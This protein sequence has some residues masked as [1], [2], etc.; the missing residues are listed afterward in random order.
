MLFINNKYESLQ[1]IL[2][3][4]K[5]VNEVEVADE[6]LSETGLDD[7]TSFLKSPEASG[8]SDDDTGKYKAYLKSQSISKLN[9]EKYDDFFSKRK[10]DYND[11]V[12]SD[13]IG[14]FTRYDQIEALDY[15]V[16]AGANGGIINLSSLKRAHN[17]Y[18]VVI[19]K[20]PTN[21]KENARKIL[22]VMRTWKKPGQPSEGQFEV[23]L[24]FVLKGG[25]REGST[26]DVT[27][28]KTKMEVKG[29]TV[30]TGA[31]MKGEVDGNVLDQFIP[32][33]TLFNTL[34]EDKNIIYSGKGS[35]LFAKRLDNFKSDD[36]EDKYIK[37][38]RAIVEGA[39][40]QVT[41]DI[42]NECVS[43]TAKA[44]QSGFSI[45]SVLGCVHLFYYHLA[46]NFNA[47]IVIN[48]DNGDC[49]YTEKFLDF[50]DLINHIK[51][52]SPTQGNSHKMSGIMWKK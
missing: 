29:C 28:G 45:T 43:A 41:E 46:T 17:I 44:L 4:S 47:L 19:N 38:A 37:V 35:E 10:I 1:S 31:K 33:K 13:F 30:Q 51:F 20:W 27:V 40:S 36:G 15:V 25:G 23:L 7:M 39:A 21:D 5:A 50:S 52:S 49:F 24:R 18:D 8:L 16:D 42:S 32:V 2:E 6:E 3:R 48:Q 11:D 14:L 9:K 12:S 26:G 34:E 22:E